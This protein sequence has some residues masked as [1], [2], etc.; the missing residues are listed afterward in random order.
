MQLRRIGTIVV[1]CGGLGLAGLSLLV[2]CGADET[3]TSGTQV[4]LTP[5]DQEFIKGM[6][7]TMK[8]QRAESRK[9]LTEDQKKGK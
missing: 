8:Q 4:Q 3:K 6:R 5:E 7:G 9:A 2:G 1:A